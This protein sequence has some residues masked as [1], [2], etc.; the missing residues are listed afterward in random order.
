MRVLI[1]GHMLGTGEGGNER[2]IKN[3]AQ[4]LQD[5]K[6]VEVKIAYK[7]D[8]GRNDFLRLFYTLPKLSLELKADIIHS[9]YILPFF[10][11]AKFVVTVHDFSFCEYPEFFSPRERVIFKY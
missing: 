7:K 9:T 10:K 2:Y 1:D 11:N 3:L 4:N 8:L 5:I 6:D